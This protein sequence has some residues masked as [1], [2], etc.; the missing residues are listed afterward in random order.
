MH[1]VLARVG[2]KVGG[3]VVDS[4]DLTG[5][6]S[7]RSRLDQLQRVQQVPTRALPNR[8]HNLLVGL[9]RSCSL[10]PLFPLPGPLLLLSKIGKANH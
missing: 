2:A 1:A 5:F 7:V 3:R 10:D 6:G 4:A 8:G 9:V